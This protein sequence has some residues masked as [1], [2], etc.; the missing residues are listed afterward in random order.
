VF[1]I[2]KLIAADH[3]HGLTVV[4]ENTAHGGHAVGS[5]LEDFAAV[6]QK[7]ENPK[8]LKFCIDVAH[9]YL[10]GYNVTTEVG[11][12]KF[13]QLVDDIVGW[14]NVE[15][16]HLNDT[17]EKLG[18]KIDQHYPTGEGSIGESALMR[19]VCHQ[20]IKTIP[21]LLEVPTESEEK[22]HALVK[23]VADWYA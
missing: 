1:L 6:L 5:D 12:K 10:F 18:A 20:K 3:T 22:Q 16:I 17:Q 11:Q 2:N 21:V 4:L 13:I 14:N 15:L 8:K 9:A 7:I 23:K 19:F